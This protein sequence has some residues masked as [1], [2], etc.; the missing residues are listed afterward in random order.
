MF[1]DIEAGADDTDD[2]EDDDDEEEDEEDDNDITDAEDSG[3][4][5]IQEGARDEQG[6]NGTPSERSVSF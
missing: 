5:A 1:L 6:D 3:E 2:D 4:D